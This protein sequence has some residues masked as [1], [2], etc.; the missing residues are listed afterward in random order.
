MSVTF[1]VTVESD[2]A[3]GQSNIQFA[4]SGVTS[5]QPIV[6][7]ILGNDP[8]NIKNYTLSDDFGT[9]Y[10]WTLVENGE[11]DANSDACVTWI[12]TGG[13]GTSGTI[14]VSGATLSGAYVGGVAIAASGAST[15]SGLLAIDV[16]TTSGGTA[17]TVATLTLTPSASGE[18]A[19]FFCSAPAG[20]TSPP[21][22]PFVNTLIS[23]GAYKKGYSS[24]YASPA[25][26][27]PLACAW[28][29]AGSE[30]WQGT[31]LILKAPGAPAPKSG[32][33]LVA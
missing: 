22:S 25:S 26:G 9:P 12:G 4:M 30:T 27:S 11:D 32:M 18:G 3:H 21:S 1:P 17:D 29:L 5:G 14:T 28:V 7:T 2:V 24:V 13:A 6:V 23:F 20:F 33:L 19:L 10:T 15:A 8:A 16:R 31:A